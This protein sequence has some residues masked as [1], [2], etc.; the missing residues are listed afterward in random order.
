MSDAV[1]VHDLFARRSDLT[2]EQFSAYWS[3]RHAEIATS[4]TQIKHYVQSHRSGD[5]RIVPALGTTWPDG[6]AETWY[7]DLASLEEMVGMTRFSEELMVDETNFMNL[8]EPR[9]LLA[10]E[11]HLVDESG[12]DPN[13]RGVKLLLFAARPA[14]Y[15][16][17]DFL[18]GWGGEDDAKLG[19]TLGATRHVVCTPVTEGGVL[20]QTDLEPASEE[21][22]D[23]VSYD[24]VRELW[25]TGRAAFESAIT[26][27]DATWG[28]L[29]HL[30]TIDQ[31]RSITLLAEERVIIP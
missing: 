10:S 30:D 8:S 24:G 4:F 2:F 23:R 15:S 20:I 31:A 29:L 5:Q 27:E 14:G 19:R 22:G 25:W 6:C 21:N 18:A 9:P 16:R 3:S 7:D 1:K 12:F 17:K 11:E 26:A 13:N 28:Q